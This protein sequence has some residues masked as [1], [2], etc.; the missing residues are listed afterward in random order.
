MSFLCHDRL[1]IDNAEAG[2]DS[3][4]TAEPA[5]LRAGAPI[6]RIQRAASGVM[7]IL[8]K[9]RLALTVYTVKLVIGDG[10]FILSWSPPTLFVS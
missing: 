5:E 10:E 8:E 3:N 6:A 1:A 4:N 7:G 2:R 9:S